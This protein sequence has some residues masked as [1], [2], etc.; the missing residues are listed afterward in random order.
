MAAE[1]N[2]SREDEVQ[3]FVDADAR[4]DDA[5]RPFAPE[6]LVACDECLRANAPTRMNCLYCGAALPRTRQSVALRRPVLKKLEEWEHGF[7]VVTLARAA[8]ALTAEAAD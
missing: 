8:G 2:L 1:E 3:A 6:Q 4:A 5:P 7:N